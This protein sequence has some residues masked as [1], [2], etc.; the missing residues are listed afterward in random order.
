MTNTRS[1]GAGCYGF[2]TM[3]SSEE[4]TKCIQHL[5]QTEF[6]G[7]MISVEKAK[8]EPGTQTVKKTE[9]K[10]GEKKSEKTEVKKESELIKDFILCCLFETNNQGLLTILYFKINLFV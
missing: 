3:S 8:N 10:P 4:A 9:T 2:I 7:K 1:P 5:N 6:H